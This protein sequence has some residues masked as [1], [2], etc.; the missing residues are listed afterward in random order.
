MNNAVRAEYF[1]R[2][3][4]LLQQWDQVSAD[5]LPDCEREKAAMLLTSYAQ[6]HSSDGLAWDGTWL[7][8]VN[9]RPSDN[10]SGALTQP[11]IM[12]DGG[13]KDTATA[14][15]PIVTKV[16][17][18]DTGETGQTTKTAKAAGTGASSS[19]VGFGMAP[20][21]SRPG[22]S[23]GK[24]TGTIVAICLGILACFV[25]AGFGIRH[26]MIQKYA[27][28]HYRM[29]VQAFDRKDYSGAQQEFGL[30]TKRA[31]RYR[32]ARDQLSKAERYVRWT[33]LSAEGDAAMSEARWDDAVAAYSKVQSEMDDSDE[34]FD[35][36]KGRLAE[37][38]SGSEAQSD[39][40]DG[41]SA[42][43]R[44]D[45]QAAISDFNDVIEQFADY[46]GVRGKL[47][48]A[49]SA[50]AKKEAEEEARRQAEAEIARQAQA[51]AD[52]AARERDIRISWPSFS[53]SVE[54]SDSST[55]TY[56]HRV[57]IRNSGQGVARGVMVWLGYDANSAGSQ[58]WGQQQI[59]P[60]EIGPGGTY[61]ADISVTVPRG[62]KMRSRI[63]IWGTNFRLGVGK[64]S[65]F[66]S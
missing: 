4:G 15:P 5:M 20:P 61:T 45:Y 32:D 54:R 22:A 40:D 34:S 6:E 41:V 58:V 31:P 37:A 39:F 25:V 3:Q 46:P 57:P 59:G 19:A 11:T 47:A 43:E 51:R 27:A 33:R 7:S 52:Q 60:F 13:K 9:A 30:V 50:Q 65:W 21:L 28:E 36:I 49:K 24:K 26:A 38:G 29:G 64:G 12:S 8:L 63:K 2:I 1:G 14:P 16:I 48:E 10:A 53:A 62:K 23:Q 66:T 55:V 44:G 18:R 35:G 56:R 42:Y 17:R